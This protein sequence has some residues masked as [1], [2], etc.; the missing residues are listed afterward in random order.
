MKRVVFTLTNGAK[1][2]AS[3]GFVFKLPIARP[4]DLSASS[5]GSHAF[6]LSEIAA[7]EL[8]DDEEP[9]PE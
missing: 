5:G 1:V 9:N 3:P 8:V 2:T 7:V 4:L 6:G